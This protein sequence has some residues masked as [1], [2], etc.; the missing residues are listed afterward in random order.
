MVSQT[1]E[2]EKPLLFV[3]FTPPFDPLLK[4]NTFFTWRHCI[5][6]WLVV[7]GESKYQ[8]GSSKLC[9]CDRP[10][11]TVFASEDN[12]IWAQHLLGKMWPKAADFLVFKKL[13]ETVKFFDGLQVA[14]VVWQS[15]SCGGRRFYCGRHYP[16][17]ALWRFSRHLFLIHGSSHTYFCQ[18]EH[19][20]KSVKAG[21]K[22][23]SGPFQ[24]SHG[25]MSLTRA[26]SKRFLIFL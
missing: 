6:I 23:T 7:L 17:R 24:Y 2:R 19:N 25:L 11:V 15:R 18:T 9:V 8:K 12:L 3:I 1:W 26:L 13:W 16:G 14:C 20:L 21:P 5:A 4:L 10:Y 22:C